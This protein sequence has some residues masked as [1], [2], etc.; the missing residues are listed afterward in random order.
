MSSEP[1]LEQT[2]LNLVRTRTVI[3]KQ[4]L[5]SLYVDLNREKGSRGLL[6]GPLR[7]PIRAYDSSLP[8]LSTMITGSIKKNPLLGRNNSSEAEL[9]GILFIC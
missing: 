2:I 9:T 5:P 3:M 7:Q 1:S 8:N 6:I 4:F